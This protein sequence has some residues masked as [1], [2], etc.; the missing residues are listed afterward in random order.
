MKTVRPDFYDDFKCIAQDCKHS[1]CVG[2]EIDIDEDSLDYYMELDGKLGDDLKKH[3]SREPEPHFCLVENERCPFLENSGLCRLINELGEESLCQICAEHPRFYNYI[4]EREEMGLGLCCEE[5]VR[6]LYSGKDSLKLISDREEKDE[7]IRDTLFLL[8]SNKE[9]DMPERFSDVMAVFHEKYKPHDLVFW[10]DYLLT[11]ERLDESW[12]EKLEALK[13]NAGSIASKSYLNEIKY[14]RLCQYLIFR[15][16]LDAD[17]Y[18]PMLEFC[19]LAT[20]LIA[21]L[22]HICGFDPEH[23][24]L[25]SSEIEYS[26]ENIP[27]ILEKLRKNEE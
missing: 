20:E 4:E 24:R 14:E 3:I 10:A 13:K 12:T 15:H 1:C 6:L 19:I 7:E 8:L 22:D 9:K 5:A 25:F 26:D 11:L 17:E 18:A 23:T 2:W 27:L 16:V 21:A